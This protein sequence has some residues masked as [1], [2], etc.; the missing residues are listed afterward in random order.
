M[1]NKINSIEDNGKLIAKSVE[2]KR[3]KLVKSKKLLKNGNLLYF[4][5]KKVGPNFLI[6]NATINFNR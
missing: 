2:P 3:K 6:S 4:D 5:I 1:T